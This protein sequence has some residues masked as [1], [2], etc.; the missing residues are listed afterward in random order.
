M[1][2][3]LP[4]YPEYRVYTKRED[5]V[6]SDVFELFPGEFDGDIRLWNPGSVYVREDVFEPFAGILRKI[7]PEFDWY[8]ETRLC[9]PQIA[10]FAD[11]LDWM[12][13]SILTAH[14]PSEV[15]AIG[16]SFDV[17]AADFLRCKSRLARMTVDLSQVA[18]IA[19]RR[20]TSL[21]I[22]GL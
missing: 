12:T 10:V 22:L 1:C 15:K 8:G 20:E 7:E 13:E 9:G 21:W 3:Q 5:F 4:E 17:G 16:R 11:E 18:T 2:G 19:L 14:S 6:G